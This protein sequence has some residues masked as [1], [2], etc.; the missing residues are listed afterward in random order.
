MQKNKEKLEQI[1][2]NDYILKP[3]INQVHKDL[4]AFCINEEFFKYIELGKATSKIR[5]SLQKQSFVSKNIGLVVNDDLETYASIF[6]IW[7]EGLAYVPLHPLQPIERNIEIISQ[8]EVGLILDSSFDNKYEKFRKI[9]TNE[10]LFTKFNLE[11]NKIEDSELAYILFTSG[12]TGKPKGVSI[13]RENV[14]AFMKSFFEIGF[15]ITEKDRCLQPFDLTFDVSVQSYLV[16]LTKG[17]CTYTIPHNQIKFS[18]V[19]GLLDDHKITFGAMAPS[20]L[21]YLKPY[22]DEIEIPSMRYNILTAEASPVELVDEWIK[23]VPNA[24]LFNFYGPT[25]ATIYCTYYEIDRKIE[26]KSLN[27]MYSIGKAMKGLESVILFDGAITKKPGIKGELC[28]AGNQVTPGYWKNESKN[29]DSFIIKKINH[30]ELRFYRTGDSCYFD[31]DGDILLFGRIDH[32]VKI[33][34]YRIELGEIEYKVRDYLN[35]VNAIAIAF[36]NKNGNTELALFIESSE[37]SSDDVK[38]YLATKLP[39]YM[40]PSKLYFLKEFPLNTSGKINRL[41]LK[42]LIK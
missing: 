10:L 24:R 26:N 41:E 14:G 15:D 42:S 22:F 6:A 34:G 3:F 19:Y 9:N 8:A 36:T 27:G 29:K 31:Q 4:N 40:I 25:E 39:L 11:I 18:Y 33:Q 35:G 16:P 37:V 23:C 30:N 7:L 2:F 28:I 5:D 20:M 12:S 38:N 21:R 13:T 17:A 32:Q 1:I